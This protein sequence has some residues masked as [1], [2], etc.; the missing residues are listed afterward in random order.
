MQPDQAI[1]TDDAEIEARA[2]EIRKLTHRMKTDIYKVGEHLLEVKD[3]LPHG[4][5]LP[6]IKEEFGWKRTTAHRFMRVAQSFKCSTVKHLDADDR[7]VYKLAAPSTPE[8]AREEA[9]QRS[10]E[11]EHISHSDAE[12]LIESYKDESGDGPQA[13][14]TCPECGTQYNDELDACP[15]CEPEDPDHDPQTT[16][17]VASQVQALIHDFNLTPA[18]RFEREKEKFQPEDRDAV[19]DALGQFAEKCQR[20]AEK[21]RS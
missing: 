16:S 9:V 18:R 7:A 20:L 10:R 15:S 13:G 6:W 5:F 21:V 12:S 14:F 1:R 2:E 17:E 4:E 3:M 11:G 8:R 19:A